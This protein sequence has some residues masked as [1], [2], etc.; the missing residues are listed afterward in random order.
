VGS[1]S[2]G[3]TGK[4]AV[5]QLLA[6]EIAKTGKRVT[7]LA[8]GYK[9]SPGP[10]IRI[11]EERK[12]AGYLGDELAMLAARG[13]EV[14][15]APDRVAGAREAFQ[16]G[17]EVVLMDD[18]FQHRRLARDL[19]V[20]VVDGQWPRGGGPMPVG[21]EREGL[22]ALRRA[23][24]IWVHGGPLPDEMAA[25]LRPGVPRVRASLQPRCWIQDG[26]SIPLDSL[27]GK[28]VRAFAGIGRPGRFLAQLL[29]L[30]LEVQEWKA[31]PDHHAFRPA[32]VE[33]LRE[34]SA[35]GLLVTTEKDR[36]RLPADLQVTVLRVEM[37]VET[38]EGDFLDLLHRVLT[39]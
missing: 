27:K 38:G 29:E 33:R 17:A 28:P 10:A 25:H 12:D 3:G 35:R 30:G 22:G 14:L 20:V 23:D 6:N 8:R 26:I 2:A 39:A 37:Q 16:R 4:T 18:G 15:S 36:V 24:A 11:A 19:D 32:E 31:F 13:I 5:T 21:A 1:L 9:R 7:V 34:W